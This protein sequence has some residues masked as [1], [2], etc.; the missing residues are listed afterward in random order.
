MNR[1][2]LDWCFRD[3]EYKSLRVYAFAERDSFDSFLDSPEL[4]AV[5][6]HFQV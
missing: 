6:D 1:R 3:N 5:V 4:Y 2:E